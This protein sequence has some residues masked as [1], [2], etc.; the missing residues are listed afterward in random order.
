MRRYFFQFF[1]FFV[2]LFLFGGVFV[3]G[4]EAA[5]LKFDTSS[6]STTVGNTFTIQIIVDTQGSDQ[7][8]SV[9]A[10]VKFDSAI[11][12][13][14]SVSPGS[15]FP[16]VSQNITPGKVYVAGYVD[17]PATSKTGSGTVA[18]ITFKANTNGSTTLSYDCQ[19]GVN[20]TS[21]VI[22]N[23]INATNI[24]VCGS[25]GSATVT[26]GGG[27]AA[28]TSNPTAAPTSSSGSTTTSTPSSLPQSGALDNLLKVSVPGVILLIV[29]IL[30]KFL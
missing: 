30:F 18:T 7:I 29:G 24:I 5:I 14:V 2:A 9:D 6:I 20:E 26:V 3:R 28:P 13:A 21:K 11:L 12:Q 17:D 25:N 10:Y 15:F 22:K 27:T 1:L 16:S 4:A 23:D 8:N 19:T